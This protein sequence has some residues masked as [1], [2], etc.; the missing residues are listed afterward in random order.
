MNAYFKMS[1][2]TLEQLDG[3]GWENNLTR[4]IQMAEVHCPGL[5]ATD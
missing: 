2:S 5:E 4:C 1:T 3:E